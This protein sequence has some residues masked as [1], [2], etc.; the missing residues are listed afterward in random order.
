MEA[1]KRN[2]SPTFLNKGEIQALR[3][4]EVYRK[5]GEKVEEALYRDYLKRSARQ[6]IIKE[7]VRLRS[8]IWVE[9][10]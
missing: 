3:E 7:V 10:A 4:H 1:H 6:K 5:Q 8:T 9:R 2:V